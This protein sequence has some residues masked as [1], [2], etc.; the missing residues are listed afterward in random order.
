MLKNWK[1]WLFFFLMFF[2]SKI[3]PPFKA[4]YAERGAPTSCTVSCVYISRQQGATNYPHLRCTCMF[5]IILFVV[6]IC[7][8]AHVCMFLRCQVQ[9]YKYTNTPYHYC[10]IIHFTR[11][12]YC[13]A[14]TLYTQ[15]PS[16]FCLIAIS[17]SYAAFMHALIDVCFLYLY[18]FSQRQVSMMDV[19]IAVRQ[20]FI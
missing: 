5:T 11:P 14:L 16:L 8:C 19:L 15:A 7:V 1:N 3:K 12:H 13:S 4:N 6:C 18:F 9:S 2:F 20:Y 17:S 10:T